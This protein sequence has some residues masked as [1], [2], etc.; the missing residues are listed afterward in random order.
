MDMVKRNIVSIIFGVIALLALVALFVP[1]GGMESEFQAKLKQ[2]AQLDQSINTL[3]RTPRVK[4]IITGTQPEPLDVFP[5]RNV[6]EEAK[7]VTDDVKDKSFK[8]L[9][10]AEQ[11]NR[12]GH[13]LLVPK[14]LPFTADSTVMTTFRKTYNQVI[15][16]GQT[17][18]LADPRHPEMGPWNIPKMLDSAAP[19]TE[20]ELAWWL[21]YEWEQKYVPRIIK[22]AAPAGSP[23]GTPDRELNRSE[24]VAEF[25]KNRDKFVEDLRRKRSRENKIYLEPSAISRALNMEETI[26]TPPSVEDMWFAQLSLWV[27]QDACFAIKAMNEKSTNILNSPVK[28]LLKLDV[29]RGFDMYELAVAPGQAPV[30]AE[31][32]PATATPEG[33]IPRFYPK[34]FTGRVCNSMYDVV[35]FELAAVVDAKHVRDFIRML[36]FGRFVTVLEVDMRHED[37][38]T[39]KQEGYDYGDSPVV[40]LSL[41]GEALFLRDWTAHS[42]DAPMPA[43]VKEWLGVKKKEQVPGTTPPAGPVVMGP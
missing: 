34:S 31:G 37:L 27:Q 1:L 20:P 7:R 16:P 33:E 24:I 8:V 11:I 18:P 36:E 21:Q 39:R 23:E 40:E 2:Q 4:P 26:S 3:L 15:T 43:K 25:R 12:A 17:P 14:S 19:P 5:S 38:V 35:H 30:S 41:R 22:V 10:A 42:A 32:A 6:I 13:Y 29:K 28:H 9:T